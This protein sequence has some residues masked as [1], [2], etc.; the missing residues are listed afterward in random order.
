MTLADRAEAASNWRNSM[1]PLYERRTG[2]RKVALESTLAPASRWDPM[3]PGMKPQAGAQFIYSQQERCGCSAGARRRHRVCSGDA[4][5][6]LDRERGK[7]RSERLTTSLSRPHR[8]V[9]SK[10]ALRD[11]ADARS[12]AGAGETGGRGDRGRQVSRAAAR[13]SVGRQRTCWTRRAFRRRTAPSRSAIACRRKMPRWCNA[14]T[15]P[16]RCWWPS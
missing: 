11:H 8:A 6:A 9:R 3:L 12:G 4:A 16:A 13:H 7:S 10:A 5:F 2:P 15:M 14:C 1:A